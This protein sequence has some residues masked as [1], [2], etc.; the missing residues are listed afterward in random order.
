METAV[1]DV[2]T[3]DRLVVEQMVPAHMLFL[4]LEQCQNIGFEVRSDVLHHLN[5]AVAAPLAKFDELSVSRLAKRTDDVARA[6]LHD[7]SPDDPR[8]GLYVCAMLVLRL[9]D[10][11]K[12]KD[13]KNQA[14]L[15][16]ML[17]VDDV[18]DEVRGRADTGPV[19][20][21]QEKRWHDAAGGLMIRAMLQGLYV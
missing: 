3:R 6:L 15:V 9:V 11:G 20:V 19:W 14:V 4:M 5:L 13:A 17:L 8:E 21:A 10:E 7:L 12:W 1:L 2:K 16:S 18:R